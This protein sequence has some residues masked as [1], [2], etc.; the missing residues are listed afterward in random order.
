M[1]GLLDG[2]T[3]AWTDSRVNG[4][5]KSQTDVDTHTAGRMDRETDEQTNRRPHGPTL[6]WTQGRSTDGLMDRGGE[7]ARSEAEICAGAHTAYM[8]MLTPPISILL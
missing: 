7:K 3:D 6:K 5:T 4:W 2:R 1:D 8:I